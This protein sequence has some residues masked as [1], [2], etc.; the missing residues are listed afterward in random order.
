VEL[1]PDG[2]QDGDEDYVVDIQEA[3][4]IAKNSPLMIGQ[5][6]PGEGGTPRW[7]TGA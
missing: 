6:E 5:A 2:S 3:L 1:R 4:L 7:P